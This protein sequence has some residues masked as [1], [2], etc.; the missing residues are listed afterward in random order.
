MVDFCSIIKNA[1]QNIYF[2]FEQ[3]PINETGLPRQMVTQQNYPLSNSQ[4]ITRKINKLGVEPIA[5]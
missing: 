1:I 5:G 2:V 3:N 4:E